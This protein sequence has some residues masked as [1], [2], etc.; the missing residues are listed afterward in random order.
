MG[1]QLLVIL[2]AA[3]PVSQDTLLTYGTPSARALVE[4]AAARHQEQDTAVTDYRARIRYRLSV[5]LG[6]RRWARSPVAAVEEQEG[7]VAWQLP[8]DLRVDV[9]GRRNRSRY[10]ELTPST[11]FDRPWFVPRGVG[12]SVR[13]FS[14]DFPATG[15]LH[16]LARGAEAAYHYDLIDSLTASVPG[17]GAI[18]LYAVQVI[19]KRLGAALVAGRIW[20]DSSTAQVVR[21]TFRYVGT[22]LWVA[23][24][25]DEDSSSARRANRFINRFLSIDADLEYGLQDGRYWM[26]FRQT[27]AGTVKI[28]IVSD[29]VIPFQAVTTFDDYEINTGRPVVFELPLPDSA[30]ADTARRTEP[31]ARA[32]GAHHAGQWPGGRYEVHRPPDDSLAL[33]VGWRDSLQFDGDPEIDRRVRSIRAELARIAEELPDELTGRRAFGFG[34]QNPAD[35]LQ[36]NRVQGLSLGAGARVRVPGTDFTDLF[37]TARYGFSDERVTGRL[38]MVRDAPGGRFMLSGYR[39]MADADP[40]SPGRTFANS[41]NALFTAHDY[42]DYYL[43]TG[44]S[45]AYVTSV[46]VGVDLWVTLGAERHRSAAREARTAVNDLFGGTGVFPPNPPVAE[47]DFGVAKIR[48]ARLAGIRWSLGVEGMT[49]EGELTG[50]VWGDIRY[51][52]GGGRGYT[53]RLKA[54]AAENAAPPQMQFRLGGLHS[55]RGFEYAAVTAPAFWAAQLDVSPFEGTIRPVLFIDAG[56]AAPAA[57]LFESEALAGGGIGV[58]VYSPLLRT[59]LIRLDLSHPISPDTGG[60]WRFDLVFSPVR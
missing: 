22:S 28:P 45:A 60:R 27:I 51:S 9:E 4:R 52:R 6:R 29:V 18:R 23:P 50:R 41:M 53:L 26:P 43:T 47:G 19:P 5:S 32:A 36:Y 16:P 56:Q 49:G 13:I 11:V 2:A 34:Y 17:S 42:G 21:F 55:V 1:A 37:L 35:A 10:P 48:I 39:D 24:D 40:F 54:G 58:S 57:E 12:D 46:A 59:T 15:A 8:N 31:E 14:S 30:A 25:G 44:A 7:S 38:A 3:F 20:V 33:Y